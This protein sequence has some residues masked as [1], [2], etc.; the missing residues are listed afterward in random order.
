MSF[1]Y[2]LGLLALIAVP[3]L[4]LIYIIKNKYTEQ[5]VASTY[6]WTLSERFLKRKNPINRISGI[7]SL[8]LQILTVILIALAIAQPVFTI[9]GAAQDYMFIVDGS[10][11][12]NL[13]TDGVT[14]LDRAK[15]EVES[16]INSST[17][18]STYTIVYATETADV[19]C[20]NIT[21]KTDALNKLESIEPSYGTMGT[22]A[23]MAK[24]QEVFSE[25]AAVKIYF[26]TDKDY[27]TTQNV[28]I[29]NVSNNE[30]NYAVSDAAYEKTSTSLEI[31]ADVWSY[32]DDAELTV[33]LYMNGEEL[34]TETVTVSVTKLEA[35]AVSFSYGSVTFD[36]FTIK[37]LDDD[38]LA[39]DNETTV[40]GSTSDDSNSILIVSDYPFFISSVFSTISNI[41][42]TV[43]STSEYAGE[44]GYSL[45]V[46]DG[47][48]PG[49]N[50][51]SVP[52]D[53]A[54]W[55]INPVASDD[56]TGFSVQ[57]ID[58]ELSSPGA[59]AYSSST[60]SRV[61][62]LLSGA[63]ST[64]YISKYVKCGFYRSF[65]TLLSYDGNPMLFAGTNSYGNREVVFA[66]DLHDS[67]IALT[68]DYVVL[69]SNLL[70]YTFPDIVSDTSYYCGDTVT[71]N[72][73]SGCESITVTSPLGTV[74][75]IETSSDYTELTLSEVGTYI[76][77]L[78][79]GKG[80]VKL[81][82]NLAKDERYTTGTA[83]Y[84]VIT[85]EPSIE[86]RD[87]VYD[88]L[89]YLFI[90]LAVLFIADWGVY[91]YEQYQLR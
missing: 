13:Q 59:L 33:A 78:G 37:I 36:S 38:G 89:L 18:G 61:Q 21:A 4:I 28:T 81:Y 15:D 60:S 77:T 76:I 63:S 79:G 88:E 19:V 29:I 64:I 35:A 54:V 9:N 31:T 2:P 68:P 41:S 25:N 51:Y 10:G 6:L 52:S 26:L 17:N 73:L 22:T 3:V 14:R 8:I 91:C 12:M 20:E 66:F 23:A 40:Y 58:N 27:E 80:T 55:F 43:V 50:G 53:G 30:T 44:T 39:A 48:S 56:N 71:I 84:F 24:A 90:I 16:I 57:S 46:F 1:N 32:S 5:V 83:E 67:D 70:N 72:V 69:V 82:S 86:T 45:Y 74:S 65:Y 62:E 49:A 75:Y 11:S 7:I 42:A 87:G 85:G 47:Y 34:A